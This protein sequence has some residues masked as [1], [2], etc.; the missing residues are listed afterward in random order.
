METVGVLN[1]TVLSCTFSPVEA[2]LDYVSAL[3]RTDSDADSSLALTVHN[4]IMQTKST[5]SL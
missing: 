1:I 5:V 3:V 2:R 4:H